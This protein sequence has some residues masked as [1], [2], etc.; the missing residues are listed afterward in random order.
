M[1]VRPSSLELS[2]KSWDHALP[3]LFLTQPWHHR[4]E[5]DEL[6]GLHLVSALPCLN[7]AVSLQYII[8]VTIEACLLSL[9]SFLYVQFGFIFLNCFYI[10]K[11]ISVYPL[12]G[13]VLVTQWASREQAIVLLAPKRASL[14]GKMLMLM[15]EQY[16]E[17][18]WSPCDK[19]TGK[20][21]C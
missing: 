14:N 20:A 2:L 21:K 17:Q 13:K 18:E 1:R 7:L 5:V 11:N 16:E 3:L 8:S 9:S 12:K 10:L 15:C 19:H 4:P 6:R